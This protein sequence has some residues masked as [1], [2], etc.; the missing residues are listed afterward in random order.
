[1]STPAIRVEGLGKLYSLGHRERYL[2]LRDVVMNLFRGKPREEE[3][4]FWA[5]K[6]VTFELQPGEVLGLIGRNGAGKSTLLKILSRITEPTAGYAE[7]RGRIGSLLEVGTGFHPELTGRENIYLSGTIL[8][9]R[10]AEIQA[11]FDEIVAFS[12]VEKFLD[13]QVKHYSSGMFMRLAFAVAAHLQP[14]ILL[15]DEV[16]AV[17][18]AVFQEKCLGKMQEVST[19][20]RTVVF[21]SHNMD[22][23][24]KLC[25]TAIHLDKGRVQQVGP[26][27][28]IIAAY[29]THFR[30]EKGTT[31]IHF[32]ARRNGW[33]IDRIDILD[34]EGN[35][36]PAVHTW[37]A[38]RLR[39]HFECERPMK[40]G[41]GV[42][43]II[44]TL[45]GLTLSLMATTPDQT[46]PTPFEVGH[47]QIDL[48]LPQL[49][50]SAGKYL[51][52]AHLAI[53]NAEWLVRS[54][55]RVFEVEPRDIFD[56]GM[57]PRNQRHYVAWDYRWDK[58]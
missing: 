49:Q 23:V 34:M 4:S 20:G 19:S 1:M 6:D 17:G 31:S 11:Q 22:S 25:T 42:C 30:T 26:T 12:E 37:D 7:L 2:A 41:G 47:N 38:V 40:I 8:G 57:A 27:D 55:D 58:P 10:R 29:L 45:T 54:E 32:G 14:E 39:I 44:T 50:L 48:I 43:V 28:E 56:S 24:R 51:I 33:Y 3:E 35:P 15:V 46:V 16:L 9:M 13:T 18:D 36:K 53:T 21:V 5:L 52:S